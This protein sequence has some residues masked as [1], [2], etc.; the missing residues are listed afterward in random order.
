MFK[1]IKLIL[2]FLI[3]T[4]ADSEEIIVNHGLESESSITI[5]TETQT[6][7]SGSENTS[8][9]N[10]DIELKNKFE[11]ELFKMLNSKK[12]KK[13]Y[14]FEMDHTQYINKNAINKKQMDYLIDLIHNKRGKKFDPNYH[15]YCD[16]FYVKVIGE[17]MELRAVLTQNKKIKGRGGRLV[18]LEKF[19]L[20]KTFKRKNS[21]RCC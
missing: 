9:E 12:N 18:P 7:D 1:L 16:Q 20:A 14:S 3:A 17:D 5:E 2:V 10:L 19:L 4:T 15:N 11:T 21:Y 8:K 6:N 13:V